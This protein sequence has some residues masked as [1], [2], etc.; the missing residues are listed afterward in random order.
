[1]LAGY[2]RVSSVTD[3]ARLRDELGPLPL[4]VFVPIASQLL[5][6]LAPVHARGVA[7]GPLAPKHVLLGEESG[8]AH[9]VKVR[10]LGWVASPESRTD[11][12]PL[13]AIPH[14]EEMSIA[15]DVYGL[16]LLFTWMLHDGGPEAMQGVASA[17]AE[18]PEAVRDLLRQM[19]AADPQ[20]RPPGA[21][22]VIERL[23][24]AVPAQMFKLPKLRP[25][26][27]EPRPITPPSASPEP[28]RRAEPDSSLRVDRLAATQIHEPPRQ[29][30]AGRVVLFGSLA[31]GL[32]ALG[33]WASGA[34]AATPNRFTES[35]VPPRPVAVGATPERVGAAQGDPGAA[36]RKPGVDRAPADGESEAADDEASASVAPSASRK[37][38]SR[39]RGRKA[40]RRPPA[41][42]PRS[43][44]PVE[45]VPEVAE[46]DPPP[47]AIP[48]AS[49]PPATRLLDPELQPASPE[50]D[51]PFLP[52]SR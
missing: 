24:D 16:G 11:A 28:S 21:Q 33:I 50:R 29:R 47:P 4:R 1:M 6:C 43:D 52:P 39:S 13:G 20:E 51:S 42:Q 19:L 45:E 48:E 2:E 14:G 46:P 35:L 30:S 8:R 41:E 40:G 34:R 38:R 9:V 17:G 3:L 22:D 10:D 23:V 18:L 36:S 25:Q 44:D 31:A 26:P 27:T 32:V 5:A 12:H 37:T 15:T 49:S 7:L